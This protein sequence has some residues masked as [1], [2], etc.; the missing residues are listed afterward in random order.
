MPNVAPFISRQ[1]IQRFTTSNP[2]PAYI[3]RVANVFLDNGHGVYG[4]LGA[5][6]KAILTDPEA[7]YGAA[8]P[9]PPYVFGKAREPLLKLTALWR[10]YN[11]AAQS[12]VYT[13]SPRHRPTGRRRS[14]RR[15]CS[16]STC[17]TTCRRAKWPT[18][19]CSDRNS[20]SRAKAP[21][22]RPRTI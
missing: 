1:L 3:E 11:G 13:V 15:R 22:C 14:I 8:P 17:R 20:R 7:Q 19:G 16:I 4:D 9:P 12:G 10:Y 21:S 5:V 6:V 18:P 2:T